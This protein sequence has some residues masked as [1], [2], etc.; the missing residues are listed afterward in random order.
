[1]TNK[2]LLLPPPPYSSGFVFDN[3]WVVPYNLYMTMRYKCHINVEVCSSI[4]TV[5]Y[6]YKYVYKGHNRALAVLQPEAGALQVAAPEAAAGGVDGNNVLV[7]RD[8]VQNY[9]DGRYVN[10]SEACHRVFAFDLHG[11]H[12]NVYRLA[13]HL[14]NEQTIYFPEGTTV[15]EAM[16]RNNSTTLT[17]WCDFNR[18]AKSKYA[19]AASL[20]HNSKDPAP[21][22]PAALTTLYPD[23][24][25]IAVW[26][27]SKKAWHLQKRAAR[28]WGAG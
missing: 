3:R 4:T 19:G 18:K 5:K 2:F 10:A 17:R 16:M 20:A 9:L 6:L 23:Y 15:G 7:A 12:P 24:P 21:P 28:R 14:P 25:E 8:E 26:S 11:M 1:M 13:V 27:K 22:L